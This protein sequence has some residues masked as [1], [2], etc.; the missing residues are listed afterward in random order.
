MLVPLTDRN[1]DFEGGGTAFF[2]LAD[3]GAS[4]AAEPSFV[5]APTMGSAVL[6]GGQ[7]HHAAVSVAPACG[8]STW[9]ASS[10]AATDDGARAVRRGADGDGRRR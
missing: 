7:V 4:L 10:A 5:L 3:D 1:G 9:A 6:W 8:S 2:G